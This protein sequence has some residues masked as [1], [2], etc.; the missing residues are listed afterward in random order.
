M[1]KSSLTLLIV[2]AS[3]C[4]LAQTFTCNSFC[5]KELK[6]TSDKINVTIFLTGSSGLISYPYV[7]FITD[8]NNDTIA[9]NGTIST[10]G[11]AANTDHTYSL[12]T[13]L[14]SIPPDF[15]C[16]V[17]FKYGTLTGFG[18]CNLPFPCVSTGITEGNYGANLEIYPNPVQS[19]INLKADAVLLGSVYNIYNNTGVLVSTGK[20]DMENTVIKLN[21]LPAG[22]YLFS[23]G[24]N[25]K[26]TFKVV[27]E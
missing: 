17:H 5:V 4:T 11:Q 8:S 20:I 3:L 10:F 18:T 16:T 6:I 23:T 2:F 7:K 9:N 14:T 12:D 24:A 15:K 26:Q 19:E 27:K 22:V 1:K 13:K 21:H 25:M